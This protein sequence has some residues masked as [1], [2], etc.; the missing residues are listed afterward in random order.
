MASFSLH[1]FED[2]EINLVLEPEVASLAC[3]KEVFEHRVLGNK[4]SYASVT[5]AEVCEGQTLFFL[6]VPLSIILGPKYYCLLSLA[7]ILN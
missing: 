2:L 6:F 5:K 7:C 1:A 3:I 4:L